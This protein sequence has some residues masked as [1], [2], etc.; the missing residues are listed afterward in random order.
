MLTEIL[1][2]KHYFKSNSTADLLALSSLPFTT[3]TSKLLFRAPARFIVVS[4]LFVR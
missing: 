1:V 4:S 3:A 2:E